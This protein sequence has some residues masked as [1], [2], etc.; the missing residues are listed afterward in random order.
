MEFVLTS[1]WLLIPAILIGPQRRAPAAEAQRAEGPGHK[2]QA[3]QGGADQQAEQHTHPVTTGERT[4]GRGPP[5]EL[6]NTVSKNYRQPLIQQ[7]LQETVNTAR[8]TGDH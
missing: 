3:E 2:Q 5:G 6:Q 8:T 7:E 1:I 4:Q